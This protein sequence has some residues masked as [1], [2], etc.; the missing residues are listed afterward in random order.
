VRREFDRLDPEKRESMA[1]S[2]VLDEIKTLDPE[3]EHQ[4]IVFL[5]PRYDFPFDTTRS[6]EFALFRTF[7][8]PSVSGILDRSG[9]FQHRAQRQYEDTDTIVSEL[10][11]HG[12]DS[13]RGRAVL[14]RMNQNHSRLAVANTD[15]LYVLSTF[16]LEPIRWNSRYG[17]RPICETERLALFYFWGTV[18]KQMNIKELPDQYEEFERFNIE[19]EP[20]GYKIED[21]C[22]P[23]AA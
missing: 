13:D 22:P 6:L 1:R 2:F 21:L 20:H 16:V 9:E 15:L 10:M 4:R 12:Y 8:V 5:S 7:C 23:R 17:W 19:Y 18:G 11:E 3:A 14:R